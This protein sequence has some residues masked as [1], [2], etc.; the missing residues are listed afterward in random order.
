VAPSALNSAW[1]C[2]DHGSVLPL[3]TFHRIDDN[4]FNHVGKHA[5]VPLWLP[6]PQPTGWTMSGL[7]TVGDE[8]SRLRATVASFSGPAPLGGDGE[9]LI[10]A[11]EPGI[12]L[13][14]TFADSSEP[15]PAS[16]GTPDA[17]VHA[18]GHPTPMWSVH[19]L[20]DDRSAYVGEADGV[21]LWLIGFPSDAGY[22]VL[23]DLTLVDAREL[24][25]A[26]L[27]IAGRTTRLRPGNHP[28]EA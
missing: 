14:A 6:E 28:S 23:D 4:V 19:G 8:R 5:E 9:W 12:G 21:W 17:K 2:A 15:D 10:V 22:A 7:A 3:N 24:R 1:R 25:P 20:A 16:A 13:G 26:E 11:E 27:T 18:A